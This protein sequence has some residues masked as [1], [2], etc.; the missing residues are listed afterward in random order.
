MS[1][2]SAFVGL[3]RDESP[4]EHFVLFLFLLLGLAVLVI[5]I[6]ELVMYLWF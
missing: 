2:S 3:L 4:I 5:G 1:L 6:V